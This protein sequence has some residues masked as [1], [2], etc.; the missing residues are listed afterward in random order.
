MSNTINTIINNGVHYSYMY[1]MLDFGTRRRPE[2][3]HNASAIPSNKNSFVEADSSAAA[4][5]RRGCWRSTRGGRT[6]L[7]TGTIPYVLFYTWSGEKYRKDISREFDEFQVNTHLCKLRC[8]LY[9]LRFF[10]LA[11]YT[12][13]F[14]RLAFF[15]ECLPHGSGQQQCACFLLL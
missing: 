11:R 9:V 8:F 12:I 3:E 1:A 2:D 6:G 4:A 15:V 14:L 13:L 10:S 5:T 7:W